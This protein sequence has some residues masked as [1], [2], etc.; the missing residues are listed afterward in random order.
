MNGRTNVTSGV[1]ADDIVV[2]LDPITNFSVIPGN[3][4]V[5]VQWT[6]P[7]DKF[8]TPEG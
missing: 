4:F 2:P 1:N 5:S 8:A 6:D 7:K 3:G